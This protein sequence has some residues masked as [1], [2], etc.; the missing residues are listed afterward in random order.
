MQQKLINSA[1]QSLMAIG[2]YTVAFESMVLAMRAQMSAHLSRNNASLCRK[3]KD[4]FCGTADKTIIF[5]SKEL[6]KLR[7]LQQS[8]ID[9]LKDLRRRRNKLAHEGYNQ[10]LSVGVSHIESDVE[11]MLLLTKKLQSSTY[12]RISAPVG[13][14]IPIT[15]APSIFHI[16]LYAARTLANTTLNT[17]VN[18]KS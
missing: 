1:G 3:F 16:Y 6:L 15:I 2:L 8:E 14:P 18:G 10:M 17:E 11:L 9:S 12:R 4:K 13:V 7:V 5:C